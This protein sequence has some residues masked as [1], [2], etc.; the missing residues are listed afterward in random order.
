M[1]KK[2]VL[3]LFSGA[4][5]MDIGF[6]G[7]FLL[8]NGERLP[9]TTFQTV[10]ANDIR[11]QAKIA[12]YKYFFKNK[13]YPSEIYH[14]DSIVDLVKRHK[15]GEHIF[16]NNIDVVTGGFPCQDFSTAGKRLGFESNKN[17]QGMLR[18]NISEESRG[19]LYFWMKEVIDIVKPKVFVAENV[20]GLLSLKDCAT[21]IR[22]DFAS[23][24]YIVLEPKLLKAYEYGVPESRERVFF[25]G[26]R[27]DA[28]RKDIT[29][30]I[31]ETQYNP[32][33]EATHGPGRI[34]YTYCCDVLKDICEPEFSNDLAQKSFSKAKYLGRGKQGQTEIKWNGFAPTIRSEHHGNIEFRRL[35]KEHGGLMEDELSQGFQERRLTPRECASIQTFPV[36]YDFVFNDEFGKLTTTDA[37]RLIGNAVPPLLAYNIAKRL[38]EIWNNVFK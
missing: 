38:D 32:Y 37:Y 25:I 3:S 14:I 23:S 2:R 33:P 26:L 31:I 36:D 9:E 1:Q 16:P 21:I 35:S 20:K 5:G 18:E 30:E 12:W 15:S 17:D 34:A 10:F 27:K 22:N 13:Q 24:G 4:G 28:L 19:K 29:Q 11:P 8:T 6:E 7:N